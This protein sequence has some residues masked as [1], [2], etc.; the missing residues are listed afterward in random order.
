MRVLGIETSCDETAAAVVEDGRWIRSNV[1]ASQIALHR[2]YGGVVPE[3]AARGH[4]TAIMPVV[5]AAM[6]EAGITP[7]GLD[8]IAVTTGPGLAGAL[9]VGAN[10][11][12]GMAYATGLPLIGV[13][14]LEGHIAANWLVPVVGPADSQ[15]AVGDPGPPPLPALCLLVSGGHTELILVEAP[16]RYRHLGRTRD[17]A[18]GEAFDKGARLLGLGYPGGPAI[19]AAAAQGDPGRFELPRAWLRDSLDFSFSGLKTALLR[20]VEPYRIR[21]DT[22]R[23]VDGSPFPAHRPVLLRDDLPVADLAAGFQAAVTDVLATRAVE[24]AF[25]TGARSLVLAGGVA[26][27][28]ELRARLDRAVSARWPGGDRPAIRYPALWL[29]TDNAAMIAAAGSWRFR[30]A[31]A[32][33]SGEIRPRWPLAELAPVPGTNETPS[34]PAR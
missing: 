27:N 31:A 4:V 18:A 1:V 13:N 28:A 30:A 16:G 5:R 10:T 12:K 26:A 24:A 17:D 9:L 25:V 23:P 34:T 8:A 19:Q 32:D 11:A 29:C 21:D 20:T 6:A 15:A 3:L 33:W 22:P 7:A 14:H 2:A